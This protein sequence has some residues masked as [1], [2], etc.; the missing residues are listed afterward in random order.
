MNYFYTLLNT[1]INTQEATTT[2]TKNRKDRI[3]NNVNQLCNK[4]VDT[5]KKKLQQ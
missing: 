1:F 3:T 5:Y 2:E 4:Y